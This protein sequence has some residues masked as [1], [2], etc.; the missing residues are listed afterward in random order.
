MPS[1][2]LT[3]GSVVDGT[4]APAFDADL[5]I[6]DGRITQLAPPG[7]ADATGRRLDVEGLTVAPGFID[8]HAHSDL[9][10]LADHGHEAKVWQGV[11]LE[12]LGQD[13]LSY[14]PMTDETLPQLLGQLAGWNGEPDLDYGWRTVGEYLD[15]IDRGAAVNAAYLVPHGTVRLAVLGADER[16]P[17]EAELQRMQEL[18]ADGMADGAMGLSAGLT[19][20]PGMYADDDEIVALCAPVRAAG[21]YYCPHHRNYGARLLEAYADCLEIAR[22]A[23][24]ALHLAHC[25]VNFPQNA[26]RAP[27]VL[28]AIDAAVQQYG[29]DVSLDTYP[30]L[31]GATYLAALLPSWAQAGGTQATLDRLADPA[32]RRRILHDIEVA[33]SDGNHDVPVDWSTIVISGVGDPTLSDAVGAS[34]DAVAS[35]RGAEPGAVF[36]DL[37]V[38]DRLRT[39]CLVQVGNEDNVQTIMTHRAHTGGSDGILVGDRPHPRGWGTFPRYLGHYVRELGVLTLE[40]CVAHLTSRAA[41]RLGLADRGVVRPGAVADLVVFDPA[42]VA[43]TSTYDEPRRQPVGIEHVLV[44]GEFTLEEGRRT[45]RLPGRSVR[46]AH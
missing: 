32:S 4:G 27:E 41:R 14:A 9:A 3:G 18:V 15:R 19:Y 25:H 24:V 2:V 26:G 31:A 20:T 12:V 37:L 44:G 30:Y 45:D 5:V 43:A 7:S 13:G 8:M 42:T 6:T 34:I 35:A 33:G 29:L 46:R 1:L 36:C 11:T 39:G 17:S 16:V 10:V 28:D 22:R 38:A 40:E 21:G 23:H